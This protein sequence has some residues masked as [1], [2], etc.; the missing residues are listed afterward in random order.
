MTDSKPNT[1]KYEFNQE[2]I[3]YLSTL[4]L[5][6]SCKSTLRISER[7]WRNQLHNKL[8]S[9]KDLEAANTEIMKFTDHDIDRNER[10]KSRNRD[11]VKAPHEYE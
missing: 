1:K 8:T 11:S 7:K 5:Y 2:E 6:D 4:V 3:E 9:K 10:S